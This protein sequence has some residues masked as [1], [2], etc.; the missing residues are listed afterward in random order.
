MRNVEDITPI[1]RATDA[2]EVARGT[3]EQLIV[4]LSELGPDD[5]T[6]TT[7]CAPWTVTDVVGH[8]IGA[9]KANA[10]LR[11]LV[12]QQL[13]GM[14]HKREFNGNDLDA[15]NELQIRE[16]QELTPADRIQALR[17]L[18]AKAVDGRMRFPGL[19]RK[20]NVPLAQGGSTA[21]GMPTSL[22]MGHLMDVIY[23]RDAWLHRMDVAR[24]TGRKPAADTEADRRV[25][26]DTVAE[27]ARRHGKPFTLTLTGAAGGSFHQ[28]T[29][30][31]DLELDAVEFCR[32]LS[33]RA[34]G[35][36]LLATRVLF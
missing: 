1:I 32:T 2:R 35:E 19:V 27:W 31:P 29:G 28:G 9:A 18:T 24:A 25:V 4:L 26:E 22:N 34:P 8:L 13:W 16:H 7:E 36:G 12:R 23:T 6:A 3:Y 10:S 15:M 33:G 14:R 20:V 17:S 5:W 11:E 30:G 21:E